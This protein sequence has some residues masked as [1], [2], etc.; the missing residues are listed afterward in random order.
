MQA[1]FEDG[2]RCNGSLNKED[3]PKPNVKAMLKSRIGTVGIIV[4]SFLDICMRYDAI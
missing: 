2:E 1:E 3:E 4:S